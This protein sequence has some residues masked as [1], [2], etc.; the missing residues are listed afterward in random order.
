MSNHPGTNDDK[1]D[2][3][4]EKLAGP[5]ARDQMEERAEQKA[6]KDD[7]EGY[8]NRGLNQCG[9]EARDQRFPEPVARMEIN[10]RRG[11][12]ARSWAR[13][14]AKLARPALVARRP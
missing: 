10:T 5:R 13:S 11:M 12:T 14:T 2:R 9:R 6:A 8:R 1:Y 7:D 3:R 4:R